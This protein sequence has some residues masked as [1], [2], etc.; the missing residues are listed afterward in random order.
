M[1]QQ[2]DQDFVIVGSGFGGSVSAL[3]L[4]EKGYRVAVI[5]T[6]RRWRQEDF[7]KSNWQLHRFIWQPRLGLRGFFAMHFFRHATVLRGVGVGGGSLTYAATLMQPGSEVWCSGSWTGLADWEAEMPGHYDTARRMLGV[8][9]NTVL[10]E[11]D[12]LLREMSGAAGCGH[13]WAPTEVGVFLPPPHEAGG[14]TYP[15][16]YF[17]G[18]GLAR[19][20]CIGCG[21]CMV[22]CRYGAKNTLDLNYL[23]LAEGLGANVFA[24]TTVADVRPLGDQKDGRDG[25]RVTLRKRGGQVR[26]VTCRGVVFSGSALGTTSLL[27]RLKARGSLPGL[28]E[29]IGDGVR[30]NAEAIIGLRFTG[31]ERDMSKGV[32]IGSTIRLDPTTSIQ[33]VR[34]PAGSDALGSLVS[35]LIDHGRSGASVVLWLRTFFRLL[36]KSPWALLKM[37]QPFGFA[38]ETMIF[39]VMRSVE[40]QLA[41]RLRRRWWWPFGKMVVT[42]GHKTSAN[43]PLAY[44]FVAD[45]AERF[46]GIAGSL[47]SETMFDI[48]TT[49]H[50]LGGAMMGK[51]AASGVVDGQQ[52]VFNYVNMWVCD[53]STVSANLGVN[54]SL[55][56]AAMTERVMAHIAPKQ[57]FT[58]GRAGAASGC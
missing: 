48:P 29:R 24:E 15:D 57:P 26:T 51:D 50:L 17:N 1:T 34:Y 25:Y 12:E 54:P 3:R 47:I 7:P 27:L 55:T 35:L 49:A 53:G 44:R 8:A 43:V 2:Y 4:A 39:L 11:A 19:T 36:R 38:R 23:H 20:T 16:P 31:G 52:R 46:G 37:L 5:E 33:A 41:L 56:I 30:I 6:G 21:G 14:I 13:T 58:D 9:K 42:E 28:S 40:E 32:A 45:G 10:G 22:G 18:K